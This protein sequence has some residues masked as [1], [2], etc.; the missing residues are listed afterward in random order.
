[1]KE[2]ERI[3]V[4]G[5]VVL[6]LLLWLGFVLHQS[7][8]FAGSLVGGVIGIVASA[9]M[10]APLAYSGVKRIPWI[11]AAAKPR[12]TMRT[13]LSWHIYAGI[14]G[15]ILALL[16]TGHRFE[17]ALGIV[18]TTFMLTVVL[19]GF[20][21]RY[22]MS[23]ISREMRDKTEI[24]SQ[25]EVAYAD[26]SERIVALGAMHHVGLAERLLS[27]V[28]TERELVPPDGGSFRLEA[29]RLSES[30]ADVEYAIKTHEI[31]KTWFGRWL[32]LHI[33]ISAV[34]YLLMLAH[35]GSTVY[36]GLRWLN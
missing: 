18:L 4:T 29:V 28:F 36:Y 8:R 23:Q 11:R 27:K 2:R 33:A 21:G 34:F 13:L 17:S 31:F 12:V 1:M 7:P 15:P 6:M 5:L 20:V 16:H 30:I 3:V 25:L 35:I 32:R 22:L 26:V 19:S 14:A 24:L 9:I 10:L